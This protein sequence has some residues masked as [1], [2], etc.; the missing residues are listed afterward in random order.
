MDEEYETALLLLLLQ[1]R[2]RRRRLV[3]RSLW[4]RFWIQRREDKGAYT[5]L[6]AELREEDP[7]KYRQ[8]HRVRVGEFQELLEMVGPEIQ[9]ED[10]VMRRSIDPGQR[11]AVTLR[12]LATGR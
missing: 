11:L 7:V 6:I 2:R 4:T 5:N 10:T 8:F 1:R 3:K 12:F 9:M